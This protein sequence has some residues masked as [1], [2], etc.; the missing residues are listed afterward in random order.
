MP[1]LEPALPTPAPHS[2]L[3]TQTIN[4]ETVHDGVSATKLD[5]SNIGN[6]SPSYSKPD[7]FNNSKNRFASRSKETIEK[8]A[9]NPF[10][11]FD[12]DDTQPSTKPNRK[13]SVDANSWNTFQDGQLKTVIPL[14]AMTTQEQPSFQDIHDMIM[15]SK[16]KP[17]VKSGVK[18]SKKGIDVC[19]F[20]I[21]TSGIYLI[22]CRS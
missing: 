14:P 19:N 6:L 21:L 1:Q 2:S 3:P 12:K 9:L 22:L 18:E 13:A 5:P 17:A 15:F 20:C 10:I 16:K 11:P 8:L 7:I 4:L